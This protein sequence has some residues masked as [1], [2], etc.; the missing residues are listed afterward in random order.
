[1]G[2]YGAG[3]WTKG[4][5]WTNTSTLHITAICKLYDK[6]GQLEGHRLDMTRR[7]DID[8]LPTQ[9]VYRGGQLWWTR[10]YS[11]SHPIF[12]MSKYFLDAFIRSRSIACVSQ[13]ACNMGSKLVN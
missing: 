11:H 1:M 10:V 9:F 8:S 7:T 4:D 2:W 6:H 13:S 3:E 5:S 12:V